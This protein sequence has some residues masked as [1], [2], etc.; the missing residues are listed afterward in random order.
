[1]PERMLNQLAQDLRTNPLFAGLDAEQARS[2]LRMGETRAMGEGELLFAEAAPCDGLYIVMSGRF[3]VMS[4]QDG[5]PVPLAIIPAGG[6]VGELS[7]V[8]ARPR[9]ATV[10]ALSNAQVWHLASSVFESLLAQGDP[11]ATALLVGM[12]VS[13][14]QRFRETLA[15]NAQLASR[16]SRTED[17]ALLVESLGWEV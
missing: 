17:G 6:L 2:L 10:Q 3:G 9:S 7:L 12:Q 11:R 4:N 16:A 14:C 13:V 8:S 1:M 15:V 5:E